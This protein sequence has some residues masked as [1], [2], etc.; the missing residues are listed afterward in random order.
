MADYRPEMGSEEAAG[1]ADLGEKTVVVTGGSAGLA[2]ESI[3]IRSNK[4]V[5]V[6]CLITG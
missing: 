2:V 6:P 4:D 1:R 5:L 3:R